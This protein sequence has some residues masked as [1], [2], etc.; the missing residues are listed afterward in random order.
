MELMPCT[1]SLS[2][3]SGVSASFDAPMRSAPPPLCCC[4]LCKS[5]ATWPGD[6]LLLCAKITPPRRCPAIAPVLLLPCAAAAV[7]ML[8]FLLAVAVAG[9]GVAERAPLVDV[10]AAVPL[11]PIASRRS[12]LGACRSFEEA[13][14]LA[15]SP[16]R[17]GTEVA[18][19][20]SPNPPLLL[21][22]GEEPS[23]AR[24]VLPP[25]TPTPAPP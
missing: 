20:F 17:A 12:P 2:K 21:S 11:I 25:P 1:S 14:A 5:A 7:L 19:R 13:K 22:V 9:S 3:A 6:R 15:L 23:V 16:R 8:L 18:L 10:A 4:C 24:C